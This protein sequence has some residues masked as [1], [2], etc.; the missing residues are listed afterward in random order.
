VVQHLRSHRI[1]RGDGARYSVV[2]PG[3]AAN[4]CRSSGTDRVSGVR[5]HIGSMRPW[6]GMLSVGALLLAVVGV[7]GDSSVDQPV[8]EID[9]G[10]DDGVLWGDAGMT[11]GSSMVI[12]L[13]WGVVR[14]MLRKPDRGSR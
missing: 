6:S 4:A 13:G 2:M 7:P 9:R 10:G 5:N 11:M 8:V 14:R 12:S 3:V 1:R